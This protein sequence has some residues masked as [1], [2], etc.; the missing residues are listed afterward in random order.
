MLAVG[1]QRDFD[2]PVR[3]RELNG[4]RKQVPN[5]LLQTI[6][7]TIDSLLNVSAPGDDLHSLTLC[8]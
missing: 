2:L 7:I 3:R 5:D 6:R 8:G 1:F 4:V